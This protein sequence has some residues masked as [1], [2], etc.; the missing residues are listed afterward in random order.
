MM[1]AEIGHVPGC[2]RAAAREFCGDID[3]GSKFQFHSAEGFRL[4]EAKQ[5]CLV[6]QLLIFPQQRPFILTAGGA[7]AQNWHDFPSPRNS[8]V[9]ADVRKVQLDRLLQ[10]AGQSS[11]PFLE[12]HL[13]FPPTEVLR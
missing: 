12:L 4:V 7:L 1:T 10:R 3:D 8:F 11:I 9:I 2:R 13:L 6:Q 5:P